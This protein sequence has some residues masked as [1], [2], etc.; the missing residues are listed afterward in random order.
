MYLI[1]LKIK[2]YKTEII[3]RNLHNKIRLKTAGQIL[4][5]LNYK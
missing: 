2:S 3:Q 5:V 4:N 1:Q